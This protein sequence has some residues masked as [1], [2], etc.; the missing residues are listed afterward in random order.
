MQLLAESQDYERGGTQKETYAQEEVVDVACPLCAGL[1]RTPLY[2]EHGS[3]GVVRCRGCGLVYTSPRLK[4]PE[5]IYCGSAERYYAE[6]RLIFE[7][8]ATHHRDPNY[9]AELAT[10]GRFKKPGRILDVGCNMGMLLRLAV[11]NGWEAVGLEPSPSLSS[12]AARHGFKVHNC[13]LH[14]LSKDQEGSFDVVALSDV[15]E[16]IS[17]PLAFLAEVQRFVKADGVVYVKV[18]NARWSILKQRLLALAGRRPLRGLWDSY[19][20]VVHYTD[21]TLR[22][23]LEKAGLRVAWLGIEP[24]IQTPN[25]HE[26]V[27]HYYQYPTPWP[28][29]WRRKT[30]RRVFY[31]LSRIERLAR[32]GSIGYCA[33]NVVAVAGKR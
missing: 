21:H 10:I 22:K 27:G 23:M 7:G 33:P 9:R 24:P 3:I 2:V 29:D 5:Q 1:E 18:P 15:F 28:L 32:G 19:E 26:L 4:S 8:R 25:W 31:L 16:H 6:A 13:F 20:H 12:L 11:R 30:V 17:S 14:E